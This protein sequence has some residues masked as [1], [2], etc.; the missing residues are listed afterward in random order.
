MKVILPVYTIMTIL[1]L[2]PVIKIFASLL[3]PAMGVFG[4]PGE[5]ALSLILS[6]FINLYAGIGI[7]PLL[8]LSE[9]QLNTLALMLLI[10]HSQ[11]LETAVFIRLKTRYLFLLL[12]R[13]AMAIVIGYLVSR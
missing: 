9:K 8:N 12:L 1:S 4:L 3:K 2:T 7:I 11:I 10:S 13:I 5:C 6:N